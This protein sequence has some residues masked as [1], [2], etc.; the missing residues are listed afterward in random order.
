MCS[1]HLPKRGDSDFPLRSALIDD[2]PSS[3]QFLSFVSATGSPSNACDH[4][5]RSAGNSRALHCASLLFSQCSGHITVASAPK[6]QSKSG[7]TYLRESDSVTTFCCKTYFAEMLI[8]IICKTAAQL[9]VS[10]YVWLFSF[11]QHFGIGLLQIN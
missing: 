10:A 4:R 9:Y 6:W 11:Y 3:C 1:L 5:C 8:N 2:P 7:N